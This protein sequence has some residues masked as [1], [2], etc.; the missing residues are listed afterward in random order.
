MATV[1]HLVF[2]WGIF[3]PPTKS[4]WCVYHCAKFGYDQCSSFDNMNV[5][6]FCAFGW[7]APIHTPRNWGFRAVRPPK[8]AA[9]WTKPKDTPLRVFAS[10]EPSSVK[11]WPAVWPV[12]EILLKRGYKLK[13]VI[14]HLFAQK[15]LHWG[16]STKFCTPVEVLA[17][18]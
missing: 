12:G 5:S 15:P 16:I 18:G 8:W 6:I 13:M 7:K 4:T 11:I 2:V 14:F 17:I 1:H 10:F 3:G 9:I